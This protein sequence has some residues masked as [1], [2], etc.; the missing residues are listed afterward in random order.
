MPLPQLTD[1]QRIE[2]GI[3]PGLV[4]YSCGLENAQDLIDDLAQALDQI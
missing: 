2:A 1:E 3:S 4:R